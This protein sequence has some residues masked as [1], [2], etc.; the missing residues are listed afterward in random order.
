MF[1]QFQVCVAADELL[2][3]YSAMSDPGA[4]ILLL[5]A[6]HN[7]A[8]VFIGSAGNPAVAAVDPLA[9][10][11]VFPHAMQCPRCRP[12][13]VTEWNLPAVVNFLRTFYTLD[14]AQVSLAEAP[15]VDG[16]DSA[17]SGLGIL[18]ICVLLN[19]ATA[20]GWLYMYTARKRRVKYA[21]KPHLA[22]MAV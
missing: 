1:A 18:S 20:L 12:N 6:I 3:V 22:S 13:N 21:G 16:S 10:K 14:S 9:V 2:P 4:G 17:S 7:K 15:R 8:N 5:W 11:F 19:V